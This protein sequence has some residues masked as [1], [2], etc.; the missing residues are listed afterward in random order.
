MRIF[1]AS[2]KKPIRATTNYVQF[3]KKTHIE[4]YIVLGGRAPHI[5][6]NRNK[7]KKNPKLL[8]H[9]KYALKQKIILIL[10]IKLQLSISA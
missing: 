7:K 9:F 6:K 1:Q 4:L 10:K 2:L 5:V 8:S 3:A